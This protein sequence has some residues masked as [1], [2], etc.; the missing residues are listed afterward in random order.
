MLHDLSALHQL[1]AST[2]V[3]LRPLG[4]TDGPMDDPQAS[5][6]LAGGACWFGLVQLIARANGS[7]VASV[8]LPVEQAEAAIAALPQHQRLADLWRNLIKPR[9]ALPL[10]QRVLRFDRPMIAGIVNVTP[11]SF[12]DG[13][14]HLDADRAVEAVYAQSA[15]GAALVDIGAESTRPGAKPVWEGDEI[16]RLQPVLERLRSSEIALSVD[17]RKA[18][19]MDMALGLAPVIINDVSALTYDPSSLAVICKS[20]APVILMHAQGDPATM[21]DAPRYSNVLFDVFDWLEARIAQ[22]LAAGIVRE[23]IIVDPGIGFGK[24]V[25]HNLALLNGLALFHGLGCPL[26]LGASRKRFIGAL[27]RE[28]PVDGRLGG[29]LAAMLKGAGQGAQLL[30]VHDVEASVQALKI[31]QGLRDGALVAGPS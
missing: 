3:Y 2:P 1:D 24:S 30:R 9:P 7:T 29:S 19:V 13:G 26:M 20:G 22:C 31:W 6:R 14:M 17:T 21:Q 16:A 18:A 8:I 15:H 23:K 27:S 12:S 10:G 25:A 28:E 4:W 11:D 5:I